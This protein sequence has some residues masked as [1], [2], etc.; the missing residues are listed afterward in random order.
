MEDE[1][2]FLKAMRP[3]DSRRKFSVD[4]G[5]AELR[6][7]YERLT[8][9]ERRILRDSIR[10]ARRLNDEIATLPITVQISMKVELSEQLTENEY[11]LVQIPLLAMERAFHSWDQGEHYV[12]KSMSELYG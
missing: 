5:I 1:S 3:Y 11:R 2:D 9:E 6:A 12:P 7:M 10:K 4:E 8:T